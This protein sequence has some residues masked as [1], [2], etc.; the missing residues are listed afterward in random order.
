MVSPSLST[1]VTETRYRGLDTW[2]DAAILTALLE[3]HQRALAA[4]AAAIPDL[5]K[6]ASIAA[7]RLRDGGRLIYIAAGSP[8][9]MSLADAL[10]IPQTYGIPH[11]RIILILADGD[12]IARRRTGRGK[13]APRARFPTSRPTT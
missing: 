12:G 4:V 2:E 5:E 9:L 11:E 1:E 13:T 6:A 10:E 8:A 7:D 3:G